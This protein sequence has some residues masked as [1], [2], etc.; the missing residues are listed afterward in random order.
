MFESLKGISRGLIIETFSCFL[1]IS[2][3]IAKL[4]EL[5]PRNERQPFCGVENY[6]SMTHP[7]CG[8]E[9]FVSQRSPACGVETYKQLA[10][11]SCPG[12][13]EGKIYHVK[14]SKGTIV[15]SQGFRIV[16]N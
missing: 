11:L 15:C 14:K 16:N 2:Q 4:L 9:S 5:V 10:H 1:V 7:A 8:V 3:S 12:S 6:R 13:V